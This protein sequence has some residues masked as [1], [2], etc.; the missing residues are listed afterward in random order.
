MWNFPLKG[1]C[2]AQKVLDFGA[3]QILHFGL[4][5]LN[6]YYPM[7]PNKLKHISLP[8]RGMRSSSH[9]LIR[10]LGMAYLDPLLQ[11]LPCDS[12][13]GAVW[14]GDGG[15]GWGLHRRRICFQVH[16]AV[17]RIWVPLSLLDWGF[18]FLASNLMYFPCGSLQHGN[19]FPQSQQESESATRAEI[20]ACVT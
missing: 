3:V 5:T 12:S 19:L 17:G 15:L 2:Q 8:K 7:S 1:S 10:I 16:V 20:T 18:Q 4:G 6:L 14:D 9:S 11:G 13:W